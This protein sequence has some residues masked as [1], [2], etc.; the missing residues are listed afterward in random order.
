MILLK[1]K[2]IVVVDGKLKQSVK[3]IDGILSGI[4]KIEI[5]TDGIWETVIDLQKEFPS[6][7]N[8]EIKK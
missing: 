8:K 5:L 6:E 1:K 3:N 4:L 7:K 2:K